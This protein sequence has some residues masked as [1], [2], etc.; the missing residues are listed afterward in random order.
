MDTDGDLAL[1]L[2]FPLFGL[3]L[4]G[5]PRSCRGLSTPCIPCGAEGVFP[6]FEGLDVGISGRGKR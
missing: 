3:P 5:P 1:P 4:Y 6:G 2:P